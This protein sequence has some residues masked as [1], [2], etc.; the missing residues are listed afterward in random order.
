VAKKNILILWQSPAGGGRVRKNGLK[1]HIVRIK[2]CEYLM[3]N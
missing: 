1:K 2:Q 3:L